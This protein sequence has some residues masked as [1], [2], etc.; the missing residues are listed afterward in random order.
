MDHTPASGMNYYRVKRRS[1]SGVEIS[2][3]V[4]Q[5]E[6]HMTQKESMAIYPNP[7]A[8]TLYIRNLVAYE[9][10]AKVEI[11]TASGQQL[12]TL[13]VPAGTL[14]SFEVPMAD[15]QPGLYIT[16]VYFGD[17]E[18]KTMKIAKM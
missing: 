14:Q 3:E 9:N 8:Q 13:K 6:M 18:V 17:G 12:H 1:A 10:D 5:I 7:V 2:S 16:R 11:F 4:R 15:L